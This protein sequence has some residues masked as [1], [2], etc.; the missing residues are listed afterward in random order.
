MKLPIFALNT[1]LYPEGVLPLRVFEARYMDMC[2]ACLTDKTPFGVC[3]I[4]TGHEVGAPAAFAS[5]GTI[6]T[7][8]WCDMEQ[9]GILNIVVE[10][11]PRF[12]VLAREVGANG[13]AIAE[14]QLLD[15]VTTSAP[16]PAGLVDLLQQAMKAIGDVSYL[17]ERRFDD[18]NWVS[19]RLAESLPLL[20]TVK[21]KLL[22]A[23]DSDL[24][25]L[26]IAEFVRMPGA[27]VD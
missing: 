3:S 2:R 5:V 16:P 15:E 17:P 11:G 12:A 4:T 13:L 19:Y 23:N 8:R 9:L 20:L 6:A 24:R 10:G 18:A 14:V 26:A 21:Q 22:E 1:V 25:L 27:A 7:I